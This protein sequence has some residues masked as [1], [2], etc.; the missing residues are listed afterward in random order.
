MIY[1]QWLEILSNNKILEHTNKI[2]NIKMKKKK[3]VANL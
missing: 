2:Y 1:K 3:N